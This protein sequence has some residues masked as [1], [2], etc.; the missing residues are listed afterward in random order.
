M[1]RKSLEVGGGAKRRWGDENSRQRTPQEQDL[2]AEVRG[3]MHQGHSL[4]PPLADRAKVLTSPPQ[5]TS[6]GRSQVAAPSTSL[7][8]ATAPLDYRGLRAW[9]VPA[10]GW[11]WWGLSD[12]RKEPVS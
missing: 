2:E 4:Q 10:L 3:R 8:A 12:D 7:E 1:S 5:R 11:R 6:W 9:E